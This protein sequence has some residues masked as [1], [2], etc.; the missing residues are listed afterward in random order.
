MTGKNFLVLLILIVLLS[1]CIKSDTAQEQ[2]LKLTLQLERQ[3]HHP[4]EPVVVTITLVNIG[5]E[6]VVINSRMSVNLPPLSSP[7]RELAFKIALP[8]GKSYYPDVMIDPGALYNTHFIELQPGAFFEQTVHLQS[9]D[10]EFTETGTYTIVANYQN[11]LD[12]KDA[13]IR[14]GAEDNR[15]AWKGE[16]NSN[17][18]QLTIA[19]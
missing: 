7:Q 6:A 15:I 17:T 19:P 1:S 13:I 10:Y 4:G 16:L 18:A 5:R 14:A 12:P 11:T 3:V 8:S 2:S 9:Y